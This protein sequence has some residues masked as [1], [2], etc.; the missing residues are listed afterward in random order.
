MTTKGQ[1][2]C[3]DEIKRSQQ[4]LRDLSVRV[5][6]AR[7]EEKTRI[8]RELQLLTALK[9]DLSWLCERFPAINLL[10]NPPCACC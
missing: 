7:E 2:V 9:M 1:D 3:E 10:R 8:A 6:E 5:I 4:E